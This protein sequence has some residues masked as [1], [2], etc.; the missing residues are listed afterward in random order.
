MAARPGREP[1]RPNRSAARLEG[2]RERLGTEWARERGVLHVAP[3]EDR[4]RL[5]A[6]YDAAMETA[7]EQMEQAFL[8]TPGDWAARMRAALTQ[9]LGLAAANPEQA[10]MCTIGVF[11]AG[12]AGVEHRD[13]WMSRFMGLCQAGYSQS[14]IPGVP[15]RLIPSIAAGAIFELIR[16]HVTDDRLAQLPQA[17]PTAV[18]IVLAPILGR[19]E[20]LQVAEP[21]E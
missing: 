15:T 9:L 6:E 12:Q 2:D 5:L 3:D 20:A 19:D 11:D 8:D 1:A 4:E 16:S 17:L 7:L 10:R 13:V 18:L 14:G 21:A